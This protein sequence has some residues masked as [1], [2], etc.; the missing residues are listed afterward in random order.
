MTGDA[1]Q[2]NRG[3]QQR[4]QEPKPPRPQRIDDLLPDHLKYSRIAT[5]QL[6]PASPSRGRL[7]ASSMVRS[8]L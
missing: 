1:A 2:G 8:K 5:V 3:D 4:D 7:H 6:Q